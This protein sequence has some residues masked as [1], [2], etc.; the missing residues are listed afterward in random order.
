MADIK[1]IVKA[2]SLASFFYTELD[3]LNKKSLC[4]VPQELVHYSSQI[5]DKF[6]FSGNFFEEG[7]LKV[8][9]QKLLEAHHL[10]LDAKKDI[11]KD[12][13]DTSLFT[14]GF[15]EESLNPK[16]LD[17]SYYVNLGKTAFEKLNSVE[18]EYYDIQSFFRMLATSFENLV[19]LLKAVA[20]NFKNERY[21]HLLLEGLSKEEMLINGILPAEKKKVS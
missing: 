11:F 10:N 9:G 13:G 15:F 18:P 12:V 21:S 6:S 14:C 20:H 16:I 3:E 4:P 7:K 1:D 8:L 17:R 19:Y 5:M 2:P